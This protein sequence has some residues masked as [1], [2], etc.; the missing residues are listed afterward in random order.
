MEWKCHFNS[1]RGKLPYNFILI[2]AS[3]Y[4]SLLIIKRHETIFNRLP[5][6]NE[7]LLGEYHF[8]TSDSLS[9][10]NNFF[11][12]TDNQQCD[13]YTLSLYYLFTITRNTPH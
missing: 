9:K 13:I 5:L 8:S 10:P 7:A 11:I 1:Q 3:L 2:V 12:S 4:T 6:L